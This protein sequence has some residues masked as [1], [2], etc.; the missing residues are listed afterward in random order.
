MQGT[1]NACKKLGYTDEQSELIGKIDDL[2]EEAIKS[3]L[4]SPEDAVRFGQEFGRS[5]GKYTGKL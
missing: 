1:V 4:I 5:A 3:G 2:F